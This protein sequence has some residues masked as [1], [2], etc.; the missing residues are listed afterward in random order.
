MKIDFD[1]QKHEALVNNHDALRKKYNKNGQEFAD[2]ILATFEVLRAA[3]ALADV[4]RSYRPHPL[5]G[6]Y[7]KCFA[8]DVTSKHR[9]IFRPNHDGDQNFRIDNFK[10]I[11]SILILEIFKDYHK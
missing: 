7:K 9:V 4:P 3:D 2:D 8:V 11:T 6:S 10:T 5:Q 1:N